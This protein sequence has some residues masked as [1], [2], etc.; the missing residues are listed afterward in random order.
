M[1]IYELDIIKRLGVTV[2]NYDGTLADKKYQKI[3]IRSS[4]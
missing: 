4:L 3:F 1:S 2:F